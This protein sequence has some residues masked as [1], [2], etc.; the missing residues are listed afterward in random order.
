M[1]TQIFA[2]TLEPANL[3]NFK[4]T[5]QNYD[6]RGSAYSSVMIRWD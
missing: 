1:T 4:S 2:V 5:G 6:Q 3:A